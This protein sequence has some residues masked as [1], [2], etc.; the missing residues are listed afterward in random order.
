MGDIIF[1][2]IMFTAD[3]GV[4]VKMTNNTG[5]AAKKGTVLEA[6]STADNAVK[7]IPIEEP[8]PIGIMYSSGTADGADC[9]V[10][11][12]GM[13]KVRF[14]SST[15]RGLFCRVTV[16]A[17]TGDQAGYAIA[18]AVPTSPFATDKHFQ[19]IGHC[20]ETRAN[21]GLAS[22]MLHFN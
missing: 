10:V 3:G 2:G 18:E 6:Y 8:D 16:A 11:V 13:A 7:L 19:E 14:I 1:N 15:T 9:W 5:A 12:N 17:D 21:S 22:C 4:A 20:L